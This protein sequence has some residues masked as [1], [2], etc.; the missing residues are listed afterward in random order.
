MAKNEI[1]QEKKK[2]LFMSW[3]TS[4]YREVNEDNNDLNSINEVIQKLIDIEKTLIL[5]N[6]S[7]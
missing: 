4:S 7:L 2:K 6:E 1:S 3:S 5:P